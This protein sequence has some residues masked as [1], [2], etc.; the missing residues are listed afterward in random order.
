MRWKRSKTGPNS[1]GVEKGGRDARE[2]Q[3]GTGVR[4]RLWA[5]E[6]GSL[7]PWGPAPQTPGG[8]SRPSP[9]RPFPPDPA[10]TRQGLGQDQDPR[11]Q[12]EEGSRP[13]NSHPLSLGRNRVLTGRWRPYNWDPRRR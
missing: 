8:S 1:G 2:G 7:V 9:Q 5:G 11:E 3:H 13:H 10:L 4:E 6:S 12:Q